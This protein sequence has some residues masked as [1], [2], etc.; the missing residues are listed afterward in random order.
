MS[1]VFIEVIAFENMCLIKNEFL[2]GFFDFYLL[3]DKLVM[4]SIKIENW[5]DLERFSPV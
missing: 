1:R 5:V 3:D 4:G 2:D